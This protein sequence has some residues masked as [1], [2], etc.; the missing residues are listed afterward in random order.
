MPK[1]GTVERGLYEQQ[2]MVVVAE[3]DSQG[4]W[5]HRKHE[6]LGHIF[7]E[8]PAAVAHAKQHVQKVIEV[9]EAALC[10]NGPYLCGT[11]FSAAVSYTRTI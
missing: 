6:A 5:I 8:I 2:V 3:L 10:T 7:G 1:A 9:L 4:L 11:S